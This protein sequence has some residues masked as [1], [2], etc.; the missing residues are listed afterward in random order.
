MEKTSQSFQ[1]NVKYTFV[2]HCVR[3]FI[4]FLSLNSPVTALELG[5]ILFCR[6]R[7]WI[8]A[9]EYRLPSHRI[10][11]PRNRPSGDSHF[12][13]SPQCLFQNLIDL[14]ISQ[15]PK[16]NMYASYITICS[17][18]CIVFT[19]CAFIFSLDAIGKLLM[20]L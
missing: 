2:K 13:K 6:W 3:F 5:I 4:G 11:Q 15:L 16:P 10:H 9:A 19:L 18:V 14:L 20:C 8:Q 17:F 1:N 7:N 12:S